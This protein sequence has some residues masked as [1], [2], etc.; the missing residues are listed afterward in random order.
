M[1]PPL[2]FDNTVTEVLVIVFTG[3]Y[4]YDEVIVAVFLKKVLGNVLD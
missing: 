2:V 1:I 4:V 3:R